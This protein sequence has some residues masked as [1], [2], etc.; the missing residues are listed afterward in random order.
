MGGGGSEMS[1]DW[2]GGG[3]HAVKTLKV[4][5]PGPTILTTLIP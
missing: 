4:L 3:R 5:S 2:G 1:D